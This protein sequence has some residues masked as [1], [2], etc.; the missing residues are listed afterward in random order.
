M[1]IAGLRLHQSQARSI[2]PV[3]RAVIGSPDEVAAQV[4]GQGLGRGVAPLRVLLQ[5]FQADD[6]QVAREPGS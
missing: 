3:G 4:V 5:A 1:L 2:V 6:L